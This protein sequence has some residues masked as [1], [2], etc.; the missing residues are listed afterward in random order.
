[1]NKKKIVLIITESLLCSGSAVSTSTMSLFNPRKGRVITS[2]TVLLTSIALLI[3]NDF[4]SKL[5][6][7]YTKLRD[8]INFLTILFEK[9]LKESMF[10]RKN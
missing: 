4:I 5:K 6:L 3:T 7:R 1:M 10:D 9:T 2:S 8:W